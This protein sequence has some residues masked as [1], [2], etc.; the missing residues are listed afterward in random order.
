MGLSEAKS[1]EIPI[2]YYKSNPY[3]IIDPIQNPV[4]SL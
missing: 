1:H 3:I 4:K 2:N